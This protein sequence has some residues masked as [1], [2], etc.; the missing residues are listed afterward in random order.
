VLAVDLSARPFPWPATM[1]DGS[2]LQVDFREG[3]WFAPVAGEYFDLIVA[4][5]P[6]SPPATRI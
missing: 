6:M 2:R 3:D 1:P 5:P 4:N